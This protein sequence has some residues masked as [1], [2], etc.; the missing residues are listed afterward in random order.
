MS[1]L[2]ENLESCIEVFQS[3][4]KAHQNDDA[5]M[6]AAIKK[7]KDD[8]ACRVLVM[9]CQTLDRKSI[10]PDPPGVPSSGDEE[11]IL[12]NRNPKI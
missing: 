11:N 4:L 7:W 6:D 2:R 10:F 9:A 8:H 3:L 12:T 5:L 1:V